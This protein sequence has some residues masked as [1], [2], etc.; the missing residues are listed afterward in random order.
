MK[1]PCDPNTQD[2]A[3]GDVNSLTYWDHRFSTDWE[4][5]LGREQSRFFSEV[6]MELMPEWLIDYWRA[7]DLTLCDWGCAQGDGTAILAE[8]LGLKK[9]T[10]VDFSPEAIEKAV[11]QYKSQDFLCVDF[12]GENS[13]HRWDVLFSSN[14]LEHFDQPWEVLKKVAAHANDFVVLLLP[15]RE[16]ERIKEHFYTFD[17]T[18]IPFNMNEWT[19]V[20]SRSTTTGDR[21]PSYW[22]GEQILLVYVSHNL[23]TQVGPTLDSME[24]ETTVGKLMPH[25]LEIHKQTRQA[26][27]ELNHARRD[28]ADATKA[29][30]EAAEREANLQSRLT[31]AHLS[32]ARLSSDHA[33]LLNSHSWKLTSP[34][35]FAMRLAKHGLIAQ[36]KQTLK[37]LCKSSFHRLPLPAKLKHQALELYRKSKGQSVINTPLPVARGKFALPTI[38]PAAQTPGLPDYIFWG[39]IDWH[40][41][42]QRPQQLAQAL[43]KAGRRVFYVSVNLVDCPDE[44]FNVEQ[45]DSDGRLFQINLYAKGAPVIYYNP[46]GVDT[47]NQLRNSIGSVLSWANSRALVSVVQHAFWYET[48]TVLPNSKVV[49]DCMDHHEGFGN[50][51]EEML[52]IEKALVSNSDLTITTSSWLDEL[53][54][55]STSRRALIR[56]AGEYGHFAR[57]PTEVFKAQ[58]GR[59]IIGYYGAI[60][61]WFD[62]DLLEAIA[63]RFSQHLILLIGA[64]T[65]NAAARL[66]RYDNVVFTGE[67]PYSELPGYLHAFDVCLLPFKVI[68][69]TLATN[70]VK[71]YEYLSAGKPVVSVDLPEIRQFE[72]LVHTA[73]DHQAFLDAV[74]Q[75][76]THP[77]SEH[78]VQLRQS[79]ASNQTWLHRAGQLTEVVENPEQYGPRIS[80]VVVTY[81][82][83]EL[84]KACLSSLDEYTDYNNFEII[85]VD[86]ASA[87]GSPDYLREW[88]SEGGNRRLILNEDNLGFAAGNNVGL[89]VADG[90][91]LVLL[92]NDTYVT[93]GWLSTLYRHLERDPT[94]GIIG[95]VTNNI[96]NEAKIQ[97]HYSSMEE[98]LAASSQYTRANIG[99]THKLHTAAFFCVMF[100]RAIYEA[101]GPLD[102]AF[103]RGF[104]EDDD[105]C[106]RI[107]QLGRSVA[108]AEDVFIHHHLSAS[109]NKLRSADRQALFEQNK[110]LYE[111]KWGPWIPHGYRTER[112]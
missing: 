5:N 4:Q 86:N 92:N 66:S 25:E 61:E 85:V 31:D 37:Q 56:N 27:D 30:S 15:F 96:G 45:L 100:P 82:N 29:L 65:V 20:H 21:A 89:A 9:V 81:N 104:F 19:L 102:E 38:K 83:L 16:H 107:Q 47:T 3:P 98:M 95:P 24:I 40:F 94:L 7:N 76:L 59:R 78:D 57:R 74:D 17:Y 1:Q 11:E 22:P 63:A 90:D 91:Y 48:A 33:R 13:S 101:V 41:R 67:K 80:V 64:D 73:P 99:K 111:A 109:F 75:V 35:R 71:V 23:L 72:N 62:V 43:A 34:L 110:A 18:N 58:E 60:A 12:L 10:G 68:P 8:L 69:L 53:V 42:H 97:I 26:L 6:A 36:D 88:A 28:L 112:K 32:H 87:D 14:T 77:S 108:C 93:P 55:K 105:Y 39:V 70:P 106:R 103:G 44:G 52:A 2:N 51:S 49:Y 46:A 84:T 50:V 79:F 54:G